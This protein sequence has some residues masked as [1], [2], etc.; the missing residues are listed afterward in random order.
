[1][2]KADALNTPQK[3]YKNVEF[4]FGHYVTGIEGT[5][6]YKTNSFVDYLVLN[7]FGG[8]NIIDLIA[9]FIAAL[10]LYKSVSRL[11]DKKPFSERITKA[12]T[13]IIGIAIAI[14]IIDQYFFLFVARPLFS[15]WTSGM[16]ELQETKSNNYLFF[17]AFI[18]G[19]V[20]FLRKGYQL[21]Q[22]QELTK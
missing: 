6:Y 7:N 16:V 20:Y 11:D 10:I 17:L 15:Y 1:M 9:L 5:L 18:S 4:R 21:Q 19:A 13:W 22:E 12:F 3:L 8:N 2:L 14:Y